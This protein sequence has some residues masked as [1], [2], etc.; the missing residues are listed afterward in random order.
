M[1]IEI[2]KNINANI[3]DIIDIILNVEDYSSFI[4]W[5]DVKIINKNANL[6]K[7]NVKIKLP[8]LKYHFPCDIEVL[9]KEVICKGSKPLQFKFH[10]KW[11]IQEIC[12]NECNINFII[13]IDCILLFLESK[14]HSIAED[15][16]IDIVNKFESRVQAIKAL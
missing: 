7:T 16:A 13:D 11:K 8:L 10:A 15:F 4:P 9:E 12:K 14:I 1:H 3:D 5:C 2:S 6:I